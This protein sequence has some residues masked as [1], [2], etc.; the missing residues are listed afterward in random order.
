MEQ[1]NRDARDASKVQKIEDP[2]EAKKDTHS[3]MVVGTR[4]DI[5]K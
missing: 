4:F 5:D 2:E 3:Y 1:Q